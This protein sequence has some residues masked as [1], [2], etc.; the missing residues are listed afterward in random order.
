MAT[1]ATETPSEFDAVIFR[2]GGCRCFWQAGFWSVVAPA[3]ALRPR[4]VL[5]A[6]AGAAFACAALSGRGGEIV[7]AFRRRTARNPRNVYPS[8]VLRRQPV[9]PHEAIYRGTIL[10]VL[11][12]AALAELHRGPD[13]RILVARPP[14]ER[15]LVPTLVAGFAAY[16]FDTA[17]RRRLH[18]SLPGRLGFVPEL[19]SVRACESIEALADLILQSSGLPPL[20][21]IYR[22]E[23]RVV[24]DG[25]IVEH[26]LFEFTADHRATLVLSSKP[27]ATPMHA[28]GR[29]YVAPSRPPP[30]AMWDYAS[31]ERIGPTF[32]L[33]RRDGEAFLARRARHGP[34]SAS[35]V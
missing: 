24:V 35:V 22:R 31:P 10:D 30:V 16:K 27:S 8:R 25:A 34:S 11:D 12:A 9:F 32:D 18:P 28:P 1:H 3:L 20:L 19:V 17:V 33:G 23:G 5:G 7:S 4:T 29:I 15:A 2:G 21:P 14:A 26:A 6:S 13:L